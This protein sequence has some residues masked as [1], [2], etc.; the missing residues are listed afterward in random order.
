MFST[1]DKVLGRQ[2]KIALGTT[3]FVGIFSAVYEHYGRGIYSKS[4]IYAF[5]IPLLFGVIPAYVAARLPEAKK[6][7]YAARMR[8]G[9]NL[10]WSG[11]ATLTVGA[12]ATGVVEIYGTTNRLLR[13]YE[14]AG[15]GLLFAGGIIASVAFSWEAWKAEIRENPPE[16]VETRER[17]A[18]PAKTK[19][20]A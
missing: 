9:V 17:R 12:L 16:A 20:S 15:A 4:M 10:F 11:V 8:Q 1:C 7:E 18:E 19:R 6:V 14:Y 13:Y 3:V 5:L 2:W